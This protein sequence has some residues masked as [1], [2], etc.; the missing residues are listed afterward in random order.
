MAARDH[1]P[2]ICL[3]STGFKVKADSGIHFLPAHGLELPFRSYV[4]EDAGRVLY[5][6]FCLWE[7]GADKQHGLG[8][9]KYLDRLDSVLAGRRRLGQQTLEIIVSGYTGMPEAEE[10]VRQRLPT[11]VQLGRATD[12]VASL[13]QPNDPMKAHASGAFP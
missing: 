11:L 6:F 12:K 10:A 7:D 3:P 5:V 1:R 9:S 8:R 2:E 13:D 4:F